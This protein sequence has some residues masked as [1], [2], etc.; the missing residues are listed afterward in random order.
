MKKLLLTSLAAFCFVSLALAQEPAKLAK[1]KSALKTPANRASSAEYAEKVR[2]K[3]ARAAAI[4]AGKAVAPV[5]KDAKAAKAKLA[6]D[7]AN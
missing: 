2:E 1:K 6:V 7:K 3:E 4:E 5:N